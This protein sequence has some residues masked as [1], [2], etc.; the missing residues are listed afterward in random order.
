MS[1][2]IVGNDIYQNV[3]LQSFL[4]KKFGEKTNGNLRIYIQSKSN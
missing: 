2:F 1:N 4:K 3:N